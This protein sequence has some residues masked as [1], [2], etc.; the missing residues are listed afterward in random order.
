[1]QGRIEL[2]DPFVDKTLAGVL[3]FLKCCYQPRVRSWEQGRVTGGRV[4][5][6]LTAYL[7]P[8]SHNPGSLALNA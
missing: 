7:V 4:W 1:M 6:L 8:S 5:A 2:K 3:L